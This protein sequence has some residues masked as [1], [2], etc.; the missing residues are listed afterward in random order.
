VSTGGAFSYYDSTDA[1]GSRSRS[2]CWSEFDIG[3]HVFTW[4]IGGITATPAWDFTVSGWPY[5]AGITATKFAPGGHFVVT[6]TGYPNQPVTL[7]LRYNG[8]SRQGPYAEGDT[9]DWGT[10]GVEGDWGPGDVG[11]YEMDWYVGG[12]LAGSTNFTISSQ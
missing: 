3:H 10:G 11:S 1:N 8:G 7:Y 5:S 9:D 2:G 6:V 4:R 12:T